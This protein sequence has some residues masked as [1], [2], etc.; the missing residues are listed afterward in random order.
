MQKIKYN[1]LNSRQKENYNFH[2]VAAVL[3]DYGF[4]SIR[5]SD[6]WQSADFIAQH[7]DGETFLKI[8]LKG[9]MSIDKKYIGKNIHICFPYG[10]AWYL[11]PHDEVVEY[12]L[13]S[14]N[15]G[16]TVSWIE[17]GAYSFKIISQKNI[18]Y[19]KSFML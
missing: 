9:R 10:N 8:Q 19:F 16:K 13:S 3:A 15:I 5:L 11:F 1:S 17:N 12:L 7:I 6:D 18:N 4:T 2:K 14:S